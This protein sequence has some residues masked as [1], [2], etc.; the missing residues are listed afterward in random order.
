MIKH[1]SQTEK[2]ILNIFLGLT[3][4]KQICKSE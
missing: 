2:W 4:A 1:F 3:Q